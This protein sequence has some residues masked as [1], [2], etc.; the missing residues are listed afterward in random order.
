MEALRLLD[1]VRAEIRTRQY[2]Y[3][4]EQAYVHWV[5]TFVRFHGRRTN[6][7]DMG[8]AEVKAFL[9]H[10]AI[11][12]RVSAST[13]NQALSALLF[14]YGK[15]LGVELG[16]LDGLPRAKRREHEP[17]VLSPAETARVLALMRDPHRL[18][19]QLMYGS[20]LRLRECVKLRVKDIDFHYRQVTVRHGKG[21]KDRVTVLPDALIPAV[22]RQLERSRA[23][24]EQ[25]LRED[26]EGVSLP[27]ALARKYPSAARELAW[28]YVFP[29]RRR[30]PDP[31]TGRVLRHHAHES[32]LQRDFRRALRAA[33]V[34]EHAGTHVLRHSFATHLLERG[35][36]IRTVQE[37]L[38]HR[39]V[40]TTMI[41][42]HVI[43]RGGQGVRSPFD[44]MA[45]RAPPPE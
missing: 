34:H 12:R 5:R 38:G 24:H 9:E 26:F 41:Y 19:A 4:T 29:S 40:R 15:V 36:D 33:G 32:G 27:H 23:I 43:R 21:G 37:L 6:P 11:G 44:D 42:T 30:V 17:V 16:W 14:L 28:Q 45:A 35:H 20:G 13:R 18:M 2:S 25:D 8:E 39:D 31:R 10:L 22:E 7:R 1:R 3:R